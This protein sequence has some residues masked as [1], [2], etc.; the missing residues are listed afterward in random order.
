VVLVGVGVLLFFLLRGGDEDPAN[1]ASS[2]ST[3]TSSSSAS[4]S[5]ESMSPMNTGMSLPGGASAPA[6]TDPTGTMGSDTP[7]GSGGQF[8]GSD[9]V[10]LAWV[11]ALFNGDFTGAYGGLCPDYQG[12]IAQLASENGVTNED[13]LAAVFYQGTLEGRGIN[14]G[15]LDSVEYSADDGLDIASFT[16]DLDDGS[17]FTLL[18]GVDA[19]LTVCG[20]A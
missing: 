16:L 8:A 1:T 2:S 7:A 18:V 12:Q 6:P 10:A 9:G 15:T 11:Q 14:D 17:T 3:S 20:W 5:G 13:A 4:S 19:N